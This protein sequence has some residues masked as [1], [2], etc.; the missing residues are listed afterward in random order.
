MEAVTFVITMMGIVESER[1]YTKF[2]T[3]PVTFTAMAV[4]LKTHLTNVIIMKSNEQ[5]YSL[6]VIVVH[7]KYQTSNI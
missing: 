4:S 1:P 6:F 3:K 2:I 5:F 7:S